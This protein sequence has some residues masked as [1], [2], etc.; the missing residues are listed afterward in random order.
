MDIF[1]SHYSPTH[2]A[3]IVNNFLKDNFN[4]TSIMEF[5]SEKKK[6]WALDL[7]DHG[8]IKPKKL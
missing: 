4:L 6:T 5:Y 8:G 2:P 7:T 3:N 1:G